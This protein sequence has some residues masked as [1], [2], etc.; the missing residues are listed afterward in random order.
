MLGSRRDTYLP[1][2]GLFSRVRPQLCFS[3]ALCSDATLDGELPPW[4]VAKAFAF[5]VVLQQAVVTLDTAP[6]RVGRKTCHTLWPR[7]RGRHESCD[8]HF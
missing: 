6:S 2:T 7:G 1:C 8:A 4:D 3:L 5:H